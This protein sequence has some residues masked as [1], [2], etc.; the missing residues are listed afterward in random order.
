MIPKWNHSKSVARI[1]LENRLKRRQQQEDFEQQL[2][3]L[4]DR[5]P[6]GETKEALRERHLVK[7]E[8]CRNE[9]VRLQEELQQG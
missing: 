1:L 3:E 5:L 9:I 7:L 8:K 2:L 6:E 4:I